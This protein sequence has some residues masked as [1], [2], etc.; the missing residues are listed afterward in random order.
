M[1]TLIMKYIQRN[2]EHIIGKYLD[3]S[4]IIAVVGPRQCGKTTLFKQIHQNIQQAKKSKFITFE[5][6]MILG[7]FDNNIDAFIELYVKTTDVLFIDEFQYS[8]NGGKHL[9]QIYDLYGIKM[10]ITGSSAIELTVNTLKYLVGRIFSF[11]LYPF[12]FSEFLSAKNQDVYDYYR[13]NFSISLDD[14]SNKSDFDIPVEIFR[15]LSS[16]YEEYVLFGGYPRVVLCDD[17]EE[18][19][20]VLTGIYSTFIIRE[21]KDYLGLVEEYKLINFVKALSLQVGNL[22]EYKNLSDLSGYSFVTVKKYLHFFEQ[23]YVCDMVKPF[24]TNKQK[25]LV[26]NPKSFFLDTGLRNVIINDFRF[27]SQ[28]TDAGSLLENGLYMDLKKQGYLLKFWRDKQG[29]EVDFVVEKEA[30]KVAIEVKLNAKQCKSTKSTVIFNK[31]YPNIVILH[32]YFS[33]FADMA[34]NQTEKVFPAF[35]F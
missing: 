30:V 7:M 2:I 20:Q 19:K 18:K 28:R 27:L 17:V 32:A 12:D 31:N 23:S 1:Y 35:I 3:C 10:F 16:L 29:N 24:Y 9:K 11:E 22:V 25:E 4:E 34:C 13:N 33:L 8:K 21:I 26:K 14:I 6:P 15:K 5:D